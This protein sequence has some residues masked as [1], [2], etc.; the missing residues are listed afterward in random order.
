[1]KSGT[2]YIATYFA[3]KNTPSGNPNRGW[4]VT[5]I[6]SGREVEFVDEEYGGSNYIF[7]KYPDAIVVPNFRIDVSSSFINQL[8]REMRAFVQRRQRTQ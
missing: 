8:R 1:M 5:D 4:L 6:D 7:K 3:A 2:P